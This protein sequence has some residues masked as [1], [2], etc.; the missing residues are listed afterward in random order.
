MTTSTLFTALAL[1]SAFT[2]LTTQ[3]IKKL[4]D[5]AG[6][7]YAPNLLAVIVSFVLTL[8]TSICYIIFNDIALTGKVIVEIIALIYMTFLCATCGFDKVK[9]TIIEILGSDSESEK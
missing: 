1:L 6:K 2:S 8:G 3:G 7:T 5:E 9:E 4:L